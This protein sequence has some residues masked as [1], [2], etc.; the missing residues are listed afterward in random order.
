MFEQIRQEYRLGIGTIRGV[1]KQFG[2]SARRWSSLTRFCELTNA[3]HASSAT[4]RTAS[5]SGFAGKDR[6]SQWRNQPCVI[7][8][9]NDFF[10]TLNPAII[11]VLG[12]VAKDASTRPALLLAAVAGAVISYLWYR[13]IK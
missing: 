9:T 6:R 7:T 8:K 2:R 4:R 1:A 13:I 11:T 10:L 12:F 3:L 5:G